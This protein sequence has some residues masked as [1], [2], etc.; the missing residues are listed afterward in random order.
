MAGVSEPGEALRWAR[1]RGC[2]VLATS[3]GARAPY[4]GHCP[5]PVAVVFGNER[6]GV[7]PA[8]LAA[9]DGQVRIPLYGS[10]DSL[11]VTVAA[12]VVLFEVRRQMAVGGGHG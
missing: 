11:N 12:G 7:R 9:C 3:P 8:T 4:T 5:L 2:T 1:A 10:A 6:H